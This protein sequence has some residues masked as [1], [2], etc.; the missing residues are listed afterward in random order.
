MKRA[1]GNFLALLA[2]CFALSA[3]AETGPRDAEALR[4]AL[5]SD[6]G[7]TILMGKECADYELEG[8]ELRVLPQ[9]YTPFLRMMAGNRR[10]AELLRVMG[11]AFAAYPA[12]FFS[13]FK[14]KKYPENVRFLLVDE[15]EGKREAVYD[16]VQTMANKYYDIII[17]RTGIDRALVH[18]EIWHAM[19]VR[20]GLA[21]AQNFKTWKSLNPG[22]FKYTKGY[23]ADLSGGA[24]EEPEDWF[25]RAYSKTFETEDRATVFEAMMTKNESW[26]RSR[27][28]LQ[29]KARYLL[30]RIEPVFGGGWTGF[31]D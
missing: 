17:A 23:G 6:Y 27:P 7:V 4:D 10:F 15:I 2:L 16:G 20:I 31:P 14:T 25:V 18:H 21:K 30:R 12:D 5:Q 13:R 3:G 24:E 19:E 29:K 1:L 28:H 26:W 8:Y 22:G 11:E 9:G